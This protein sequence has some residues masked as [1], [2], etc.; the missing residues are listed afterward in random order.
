MFKNKSKESNSSANTPSVAGGSGSTNSLVT[1]T[2]VEGTIIASSDIRIDG[3]LKG[4]LDCKGR[5][6]IGPEGSV[7]GEITC[8]NAVIEGKFSG[9]LKVKDLLNVRENAN[10]QGDVQT[11]KLLVQPGAVYNVS[12]SMGGQTIKAFDKKSAV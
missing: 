10:I 8:E 4:I 3:S 6:I 7:D 11:D 12:C 1:G 9:K 5:V 2:S